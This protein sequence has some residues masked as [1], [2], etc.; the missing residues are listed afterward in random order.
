MVLK[1]EKNPL[2]NI[3]YAKALHTNIQIKTK[4]LD[5]RLKHVL[6]YHFF[7]EGMNGRPEVGLNA[8]RTAAEGFR[9]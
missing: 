9:G 8:P 3:L 4:G 7:Y 5:K 1:V 6:F 2:Y